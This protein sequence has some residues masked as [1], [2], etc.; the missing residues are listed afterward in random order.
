MTVAELIKALQ[1][2]NPQSQ[3][4]Y[5]LSCGPIS[6]YEKI[7]TVVEHDG[8]VYLSGDIKIGEKK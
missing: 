7:D 8:S 5:P 3:V 1:K 2:Q 6:S 4:R